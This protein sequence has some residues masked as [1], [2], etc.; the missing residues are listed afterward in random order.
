M[1]AR[2]RR[3]RAKQAAQQLHTRQKPQQ[4]KKTFWRFFFLFFFI[5]IIYADSFW[6]GWMWKF[7][8][9]H[10]ALC[11]TW[12]NGINMCVYYGEREKSGKHKFLKMFSISLSAVFGGE[13]EEKERNTIEIEHTTKFSNF[14]FQTVCTRWRRERGANP[15]NLLETRDLIVIYFM[16]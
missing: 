16:A 12:Q 14:L 9:F 2:G 8:I 11:I 10:S 13:R 1:L 15:R 6:D 7:E 5:W 3:R 4:G